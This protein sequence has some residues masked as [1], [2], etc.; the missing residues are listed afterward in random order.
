MLCNHVLRQCAHA[1]V[2]WLALSLF[3]QMGSWGVE[4]DADSVHYA[5]QVRGLCP[6]LARRVSAAAA[7]ATVAARADGLTLGRGWQACARVRRRGGFTGTAA[8]LVLDAPH[9]ARDDTW[10]MLC[11]PIPATASLSCLH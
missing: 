6:R 10:L 3:E 9:L 11:V 5:V 2:P 8:K 1:Y 4:P 7:A